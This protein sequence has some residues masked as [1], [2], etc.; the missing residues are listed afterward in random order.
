[1]PLLLL[2]RRQLR[3]HGAR[4]ALTAAGV[5][6][7]VA[8]VVAIEVINASTLG[9][10]TD[11]I[12]DL[13]GT[14]AL[15]V[16]GRGPFPEAVAEGLRDLPG[17]E[18]AV[19]IL[20]DTF[21][22]V[23][24]PAAGE[25][26]SVFAA[27]VTDGHAIKTLRLVRS[28]DHVVDD[29]L[30]FLVDPASIILTDVF[31]RRVDAH[32]GTTLRLRT[33][34]G[35]RTFTVRGI[36][37]P[38]GVGRAFGGNLLLMDVVG[39]QTVLGREGLIDQVDIALAPDVDV[40]AAER[41]VRATLPPGIEVLR[42]AR[43]GEQIERILRSY[44][45]LLS[46]I[47]GL[48]LLAAVFVVA[49][50]VSTSV[51]ARRQQI[52]LLRCVGAA[53]RHVLRLVLGEAALL[54]VFGTSVGILLGLVLARLLLD[55]VTES[56]EL[57]F[58]LRLFRSA[59]DVS[60]GAIA[61]G[62]AAG[63]GA[64][65]VAAVLPARAATAISPLA[66]V[67]TAG[68]TPVGRRWPAPGVLLGA[69]LVAL[70]GLGAQVWLDSGW[71]GNIGAVATDVALVCLFMRLAGVLS[72]AVL[73]PLRTRVGFAS[74][75]ALDRLARIPDQ[76]ALA[77]AVLALGLGLMLLAGTLARSFEESVLDFIHHQ[78]RADLVVASTAAT[79][80]IESPLPE[81]IGDEI[82]SLPGVS[83]VE[84]IRLAEYEFRGQRV[85]ID[86]LETA[87]FEPGRRDDFVFSAG[88]P[89]A[90]LAAV[91]GG[92]AV[93]VSS[94]FARLFGLRVGDRLD[95]DTP[96]GHF[97]P[98]VA[99]IVVDYVSPRGSIIM[100]RDTW[101]RWWEDHG[102]T[103]FHVS[104]AP[105]ATIDGV[106]RAI[107]SGVG[108]EEG[109]KV[110]TQ[111]ELYA[112]HQ[113]VVRRSFRFTHALEVLPLV[114]AALG[115]AE[116]LLAVGLDRRHELALM[117]AAGTTR[118]QVA[119]SVVA[120]AAGVGVLGF[121]GG[122]AMGAVLSLLW[123]RVNFAYQLGWD[124]DI[125]FALGSVPLAALAAALVSVS[126]GL[127]PA[128]RIARLPVLEALRDE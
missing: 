42:P 67:R 125:H 90:A 114:V 80:W 94:N 44:R 24:G 48:A 29:P 64:T 49:S 115:L 107:A 111:R 21:F 61:L 128:R 101:T 108:R 27:D 39:A 76:L 28:G 8:L 103:R 5:A 73:G 15:Q 124:L 74:R 41:A 13:A 127:L 52:G 25:A 122:L 118:R 33:P 79:G 110:L 119:H 70:A 113:D 59:V 2:A 1:M 86:S 57:V 68:A 34:V 121:V 117:R 71:A 12:E 37:P 56:A 120:E 89:Q 47:S 43:R 109:L 69:T 31:A 23:D 88:D 55:T 116:A 40:D 91:R 62:A 65:L 45:T 112:Y 92:D 50:A 96:A 85:G 77:G 30:S 19:P 87:A 9:A 36:L 105:G 38:G 53:R 51:A 54:G 84:R 60:P 58:S 6:C 98:T 4:A 72:T 100:T 16:R 32:V 11:A 3:S 83:R 97:D 46:G 17:V 82:A 35:V 22:I 26:L 63:L 81:S 18:H 104:L 7:G 123:V 102:V 106:R 14:A 93:L 20:T 75:L 66:A 78:V 95:L 126:A 99:G 10:F